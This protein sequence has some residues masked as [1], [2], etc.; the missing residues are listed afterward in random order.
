M[1]CVWKSGTKDLKS[2]GFSI[3]VFTSICEDTITLQILRKQNF[4]SQNH[5]KIPFKNSVNRQK[6]TSET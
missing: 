3:I 6:L 5:S 4:K 2:S 1:S